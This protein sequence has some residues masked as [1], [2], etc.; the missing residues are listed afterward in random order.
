MIRRSNRLRHVA[1]VLTG[2]LFGATAQ[3][4]D[5]S[6]D[7]GAPYKG[8][9]VPANIGLGVV[10]GTTVDSADGS[11]IQLTLDASQKDKVGTIALGWKD[12]QGQ[13]Q[14]SLAAPVD[15][16]G[17]ATPFS[18]L[19]LPQG[20]TAKFAFNRLLWR[21]PTASEQAQAVKLCADRGIPIADCTV[22]KLEARKDGLA[23]RLADL[24]HLNDVPWFFGGDA[25]IERASFKYLEK[26]TLASKSESH[27]ALT[28]SGRVGFYS[29][30]LGF[31]IGSYAFKDAFAA[32]G[33]ATQV[34]QPIAGTQ[35]TRCDAAVLGSPQEKQLHVVGLEVRRFMASTAAAIAASIQR[36]LKKGVT[37]VEVPVYFI[38]NATGT[39]VGG[40]RFG[41]RSDTKEVT[42]VA[43]VGAALGTGL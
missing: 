37:S 41:W 30:T 19:G 28:V 12:G 8:L 38:R 29:S 33:G 24:E 26:S 15:G 39:P 32:A 1:C 22:R 13:F 42:A 17:E 20:A 6:A 18:L 36:D 5:G 23:G 35:G 16:G 21:G 27:D 25:S 7:F 10:P 43:F 34:C 11:A 9:L 4:Q 3:A 2:L 40:V 31:V 14:L